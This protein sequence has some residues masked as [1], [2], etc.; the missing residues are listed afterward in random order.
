M[1]K[2]PEAYTKREDEIY[3]IYECQKYNC[4]KAAGNRESIR[5]KLR[6]CSALEE[7]SESQTKIRIPEMGLTGRYYI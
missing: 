7:E 2:G 4:A 5:R 3:K 6:Y 1:I